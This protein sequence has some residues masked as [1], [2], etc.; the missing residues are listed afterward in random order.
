MT[1]EEEQVELETQM[2]NFSME[3]LEER[4]NDI[5]MHNPIVGMLLEK[6]MKALTAKIAEDDKIVCDYPRDVAL[7]ALIITL[8]DSVSGVDMRIASVRLGEER[9]EHVE[10]R[11]ERLKVCNRVLEHISIMYREINPENRHIELRLTPEVMDKVITNTEGLALL[12]PR[13]LPMVVRPKDWDIYGKE[14]G[15][16]NLRF[17]LVSRRSHLAK[18][19]GSK[20]ISSVNKMQGTAVKINMGI[21]D[22]AIKHGHGEKVPSRR[23]KGETARQLRMRIKS[24]ESSNMDNAITISIAEKYCE[25][26]KIYFTCFLDYRNRVYNSQHYL[27]GQ[28][29]DLSRSLM[30]FNEGI[31]IGTKKAE[32][33]FLINLA[34]L[35]GNDKVPLK[36]RVKWAKRNMKKMRSYAEFPD[37]CDGWRKA[38]K[39]WQFLAACMELESYEEN[40]LNH[41]SYTPIAL[42]A[43]CSGVQFWSALLRDSDGASRVSMMP[44]QEVSDI[45]TDVWDAAIKIMEMEGE[46]DTCRMAQEWLK[47]GLMSRKMFKTPT[48]TICYSAGKR[49]FR[50]FLNKFTGSYVFKDKSKSV[51]YMVDIL[52]K[53]I[54]DVVK[55]QRGMDF[56]KKC[57]KESGKSEWITP[58]GFH[59]V[60]APLIRYKNTVS[61]VVEGNR[62][63]MTMYTFGTHT[64]KQRM[65]T[66]VAPNY[67][68]SLDATLL[69]MVVNACPSIKS[70]L[71]CHDSYAVHAANVP[72]MAVAIRKCFVE[73]MGKPLLQD[74]KNQTGAKDTELPE[75]GD[76]DLKNVLKSPLFFN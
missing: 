35:W 68:H 22:T 47:S 53:A 3:R 63:Q 4:L 32:R 27:N 13:K 59:V 42:D 15:Y 23:K 20:V 28:G 69:H 11:L 18:D 34:N 26:T 17:P 54:D 75:I 43:V 45:Y 71:M 29:S 12:Y 51:S 5:G 24:V 38:D 76:Y 70:W 60:H 74:F 25:Y 62:F 31:A 6:E 72:E 8:L 1:L 40:G 61:T 46:E 56:L 39:P 33:W 57:V 48:M 37:I 2:V 65:S 41:I 50:N 36:D 16:L 21:L 10:C 9:F 55:V 49:A 44:T 64:D 7:A 30:Q 19:I 73:L 14:G 67:I 58:L 52:F 66:A